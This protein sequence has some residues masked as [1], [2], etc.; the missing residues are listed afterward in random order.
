MK[1]Q[2]TVSIRVNSHPPTFYWEF[3]E[4]AAPYRDTV[5]GLNL[6]SSG[7]T[8]FIHT[9]GK[10]DYAAQFLTLASAFP[11]LNTGVNTS[12]RY[13]LGGF[14][15]TCWVFYSFDP[16]DFF[17][18]WILSLGFQNTLGGANLFQFD[19]FN[20]ANSGPFQFFIS[21]T[22]PAGGSGTGVVAPLVQ[23]TWHLIA[24]TYD[25][26]LN[27]A[28]L[29]V[30]DTVVATMHPKATLTLNAYGWMILQPLWFSDSNVLIV[31]ECGVWL[32]TVLSATELSNL[33]FGGVGKRPPFS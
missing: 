20:R 18:E 29:M 7:E 26:G 13:H 17:A 22:T 6:V 15:W 24:V 21:V 28:T 8:P 19:I 10:I 23:N 4:V 25:P 3:E 30:D 31:D 2:T 32:E 27:L 11:K 9:L 16:T 33:W 12:M 1:C 14:T 5:A